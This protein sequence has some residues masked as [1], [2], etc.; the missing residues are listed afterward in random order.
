MA[1][2]IDPTAFSHH[3]VPDRGT[4]WAETE[5]SA[6]VAGIPRLH[7][8]GHIDNV[9]SIGARKRL[10]PTEAQTLSRGTLPRDLDARGSR[11]VGLSCVPGLSADLHKSTAPATPAKADF[12]GTAA[13]AARWSP[14]TTSATRVLPGRWSCPASRGRFAR[15]RTELCHGERLRRAG[16]RVDA[17]VQLHGALETFERLGARPWAGCA[18]GELCAAGQR[19]ARRDLDAVRRVIA[20]LCDAEG[21]LLGGS[22]SAAACFG[23]AGGRAAFV[24]WR[25][26]QGL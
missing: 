1:R 11:S 18:A 21:H 8:A 19:I 13:V 16:R 7:L 23:G 26:S 15:A 20:A 14:G 6:P 10:G 9:L 24:G 5:V 17:R 25:S 2:S 22:L 3:L 4:L 12:Q